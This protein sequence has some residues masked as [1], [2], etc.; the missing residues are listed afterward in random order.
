MFKF[1]VFDMFHVIGA[2]SVANVV[3][4]DI[5]RGSFTV[6]AA[7]A[8]IIT[9]LQRLVDQAQRLADIV[10]V[11]DN[12]PCHRRLDEVF[13]NSDAVLLR[14]GPYSPMLNPCETIWSKLKMIV[15]QRIAV[16]IVNAPGLAQQRLE[17]LEGVV[18]DSK[19]EIV[20]GDCARAAHH[21]T[22]FHAPALALDDM[23]VGQ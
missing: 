22:T 21:T 18:N 17:Y 5:R 11:V 20:A 6:A 15:K 12:A 2:I 13:A 3:A 8:W 14:L 7:N 9:L 23:N 1:A 10:L 4:M 19:G 16:P